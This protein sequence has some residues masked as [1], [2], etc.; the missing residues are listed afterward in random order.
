[1]NMADPVIRKP[2]HIGLREEA[3]RSTLRY[4]GGRGGGCAAVEMMMAYLPEHGVVKRGRFPFEIR[5]RFL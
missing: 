5:N 1:M 2:A 3:Q 4:A